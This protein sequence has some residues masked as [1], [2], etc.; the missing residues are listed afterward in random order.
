MMKKAILTVLTF[1]LVFNLTGCGHSKV[2]D[3]TNKTMK[4]S[5]SKDTLKKDTT[6]QESTSKFDKGDIKEFRKALIQWCKDNYTYDENL[7][8]SNPKNNENYLKEFYQ[9]QMFLSEYGFNRTPS[10]HLNYIQKEK[11]FLATSI[12]CK[13]EK[14]DGEPLTIYFE[15][16]FVFKA[17]TDEEKKF[18][19]D[20]QKYIQQYNHLSRLNT[21]YFDGEYYYYVG[22]TNSTRNFQEFLKKYSSN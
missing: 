16:A 5:T 10:K 2:E 17:T 3:K 12:V 11:Q 7:V 8:K 4:D 19:A 18:L 21:E 13:N 6:P 9:D 22:E 15:D 1:I 14:N 20:S